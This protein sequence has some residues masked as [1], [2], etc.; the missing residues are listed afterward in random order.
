MQSNFPVCQASVLTVTDVDQAA[1]RFDQDDLAI[2]MMI[3]KGRQA[4]LGFAVNGQAR[5]PRV[6]DAD[7]PGGA[8]GVP[9]HPGVGMADPIQ[10][11]HLQ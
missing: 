9:L 7:G 8:E 10:A 6:L 3:C 2:P 5:G 4:H 11:V 1:G